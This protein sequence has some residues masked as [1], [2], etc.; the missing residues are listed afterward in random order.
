MDKN[1]KE[2]NIAYEENYLVNNLF[3]NNN[4]HVEKIYYGWWSGKPRE[5]CLSYQDTILLSVK[6]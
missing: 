3:R 5:K 4:L 6:N 2:A 1:V